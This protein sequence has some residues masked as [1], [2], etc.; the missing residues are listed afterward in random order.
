MD[1][2]HEEKMGKMSHHTPQR[3]SVTR[4]LTIFLLKRFDLG[5]RQIKRRYSQKTCVRV[6][7]NYADTV[8][9]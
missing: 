8:T 6:V 2:N 7:N 1:L 5:P 4:F 9:A 3:D